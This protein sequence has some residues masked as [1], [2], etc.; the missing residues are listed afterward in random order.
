MCWRSVTK[1]EHYFSLCAQIWKNLFGYAESRG[2]YVVNDSFSQ[3]KLTTDVYIIHLP[4]PLFTKARAFQSTYNYWNTQLA[5]QYTNGQLLG[6]MS[7]KA[8]E[9]CSRYAREM[10]R[11]A[12]NQ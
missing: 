10:R 8:K 2:A 5:W 1:S 6:Y 9:V 3:R 11:Y 4:L 12:F 7:R